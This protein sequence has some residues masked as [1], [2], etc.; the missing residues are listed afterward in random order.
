MQHVVMPEVHVA[1]RRSLGLHKQDG[2]GVAELLIIDPDWKA[3]RR[4]VAGAGGLAEVLAGQDGWRQL[5]AL[6]AA[7]RGGD[8]SLEVRIGGRIEV[9]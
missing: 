3:V 4:W 8:G 2:I 6:P 9:I 5:A 7:V 1:K